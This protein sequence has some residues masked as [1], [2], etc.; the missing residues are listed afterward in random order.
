M[1]KVIYF[2]NNATT[3]V[4]PEAMEEMLP[5]F[6]T[7]YG[8]P[9]SMHEFGGENKKYVD[10]ARQQIADLI[11]ANSKEIIFTSCG[12]ESDNTAIWSA[13]QTN[14]QKRR[15]VTTKVE[16]PAVFETCKWWEGQGYEVTFLPVDEQG[17]LNLH[18]VDD[19]IKKDTAL[20]SVMWANNETG[21][22]FPVE[23][24]AKMA[25]DKGV[26][27]HT[28]AVQAVGKLPVNLKNSSIDMLS[29][30]GHKLHAPKGV[31]M[32]Y[33]REGTKFESF[34]KGGHQ[35]LARRAGT[36]NLAYI[37]GFGKACELAVAK[38]EKENTYV[39]NMRDKLE[40]G[41]IEKI[42]DVKINGDTK[43]R[44]PNTLNISFKYVEGE[45]IL[46]MLSE[47]GIC[48][49]SGSAC[50][51]GSLEPSHILMA[52]KVPFE[53]AHGSIRFS[54]SIYNTEEEIDFVLKEL[55]IIIERLRKISPFVKK[56][57]K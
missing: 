12:T 20:V 50:T 46:L 2:D 26:L 34:M 16:H 47:K 8:N 30:S 18:D 23:Q 39:K 52:M 42:S 17:N 29:V 5:F 32:L 9:S 19:A 48:A 31:G 14:P 57:G 45:S 55:P 56:D 38:V 53:F 4:A 13:L 7:R 1:Q 51:S 33:V 6:K 21:V 49:S 28:D 24:I 54:L 22:I 15:I 41:I 35:E 43:N 3:F 11:G 40:K 25:K 44:L 36:E 37:A 10:K 27:F